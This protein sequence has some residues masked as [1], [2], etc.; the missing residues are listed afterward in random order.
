MTGR[1]RQNIV[2]GSISLK[3]GC[4]WVDTKL[5]GAIFQEWQKVWVS[6]NYLHWCVQQ[7]TDLEHNT[8]NIGRQY[9]TQF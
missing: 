8:N 5:N 2:F 7:H 3:I 9:W 1:V 4:L 6:Q